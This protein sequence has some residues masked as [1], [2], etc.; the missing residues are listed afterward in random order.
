MAKSVEQ[1]AKG[2][3]H[4][5]KSSRRLR[6]KVLLGTCSTRPET[7][8]LAPKRCT[9]PRHMTGLRMKEGIE[10]DRRTGVGFSVMWGMWL[11]F[12][13]LHFCS[14]FFFEIFYLVF[15]F[16]VLNRYFLRGYL[17]SLRCCLCFVSILWWWL[18][19]LRYCGRVI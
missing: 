9:K 15:R 19:L 6:G 8:M 5:L 12:S 2:K 7:W 11:S 3:R 18:L 1:R 13:F 16:D 10:A 4:R 14:G 17:F